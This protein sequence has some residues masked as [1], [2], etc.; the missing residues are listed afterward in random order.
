MI[1]HPSQV[2]AWHQPTFSI[3][4]LEKLVWSTVCYDVPYNMVI[5][6]LVATVYGARNS[7]LASLTSEDIT[8]TG[9]AKGTIHIKTLKGGQRK[10]QPIPEE[11]IPL[12][13]FP[14]T[15]MHSH[16]I[17]RRLKKICKW[18]N[19]LFVLGAGTHSIRR[20]VVTLVATIEH[21]DLKVSDFFRWA[22]PRNTLARYVQ[23]PT[24]ESDAAILAKH[25]IV[26]LWGEVIPYLLEK[27]RI[28]N[29]PLLY[30]NT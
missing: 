27:E 24:T 8:L 20:A 6:L 13:I 4:E 3:E 21:S 14:I 9:H 7:E 30:N 10:S 18:A 5:R 12:F 22:K 29:Q 25:P 1:I 26:K 11:L 19:I 17:Q 16:T 2:L 23:T 15:K 28:Y